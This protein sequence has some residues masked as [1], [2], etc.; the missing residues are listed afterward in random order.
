MFRKLLP[1]RR[2]T[3]N[4]RR[5]GMRLTHLEDR[6]VP[7][8]FVVNSILDNGVG[9]TL[10]V[11]IVAANA[12]PGADTIT[13]DAGVFGSAETIKLAS[14]EI[15]ISG[16]LIID[17]PVAALTISGENA[18]RIFNINGAGALAVSIQDVTLTKGA[19]TGAADGGAIFNQDENLTLTNCTVSSSNSASDG[20]AIRLEAAGAKLT[21]DSCVVS[22]NTATG[23]GGAISAANN[24]TVT[25]FNTAFSSNKSAGGGALNMFAGGSLTIQGCTLSSN[26]STGVG[27]AITVNGLFTTATFSN[28]TFHA[29]QAN[30]TGGAIVFGATFTTT[31]TVQNCT[32]SAN[33]AVAGN[34]GAIARTAGSGTLDLISTIVFSNSAGTTADD[35]FTTGTANATLCM[36]TNTTGVTSFSGDT[37]TNTNIGVDPLL[38]T[39]ASN[40]GPTQTRALLASS[41]AIDAGSNPGGLT[42]DQRGTGYFRIRGTA[43]DIGA[44]ETPDDFVVTNINGTGAG[45]LRQA[46]ADANTA[47]GAD[48][49]TFDPTVFA[50]ATTIP[51]A[52]QLSVTDSLTI[53]GPTAGVTVSGNSGSRIFS[54]DDGTFSAIVASLSNM[55]LTAGKAAQGAAAMIGIAD[56]LTLTNCVVTGNQTT[57]GSGGAFASYASYSKLT[58]IGCTISGN[59]TAG[60]GGAIFLANNTTL[61]IRDCTISGNSAGGQGG[62][63]YIAGPTTVINSTISGNSAGTGG[64]GIFQF[65]AFSPMTIRNSTVVGNTTTSGLGGGISRPVSNSTP[66]TIDSS[67]V[68]GN[69]APTG[70]D[71]SGKVANVATSLIGNA[72]GVTTFTGDAFTNSNIG[73]NPQLGALA[74]NGGPTLTHLPAITSPAVDAGSN[75]AVLTTDQRGSGFNRTF[76][77]GIDVGAIESRALIVRNT[78]DSGIGSLRQ[79]ILDANGLA[80]ADTVTFDANVFATAQTITLTGGHVAINESLTIT[81]PPVGVTIS[82]NKTGRIFDTSAA[83]TLAP[84]TLTDLTL[85]NGL[86]FHGGAILVD[87]ESLTFDHGVITG[88]DGLGGFGGGIGVLAGGTI[89]IS[90]S[91]ISNNGTFG[92]ALGGGIGFFKGGSFQILDSTLVGNTGGGGGVYFLGTATSGGLLARNSTF[93]D[94]HS[95][96][97]GGGIALQA[98]V[99][100][101]TVQNCTLTK[102]TANSDGGGIG[103]FDGS[104]S[105]LVVI[106]STIVHGNKATNTNNEDL[107]SSGTITVNSSLIGTKTGVTFF[108]GDTFTNANIGASPLLGPLQN[109]GGPTLTHMPDI[110]SKAINNGSNPAGLTTDQRGA[111]FFRVSAGAVDI[112]AVELNQFIVTNTNDSGAGSLRQAIVVANALAGV[113]TITFDPTVFATSKTIT[114]TSG[115]LVITDSVTVTGPTAMPTIS[116]NG[117]SRVF[118]LAT[119]TG[120]TAA[121]SNLAIA[122]G[123]FAGGTGGAGMAIA[124]S[125]VTLTNCSFVDNVVTSA[126]SGGAIR[127]VD[128]S[129][130]SLT[131]IGCAFANNSAQTNGGALVV[132]LAPGTLLV[133]DSSFT[134]N[135]V[136]G[137]GGAIHVVNPGTATIRNTTISSNTAGSDGGGIYVSFNATLNIQNSTITNNVATSGKGGGIGRNTTDV[138]TIESSIV[139]GNTNATA[140]D[141]S[142]P[143]SVTV[144]TSLIGSTVGVTGTFTGDTFTNANIGVNPLLGPLANNGGLTQTH[145]LLAG[146]PA[147]GNGSNPA[148][149]TTDQR[150]AG[151]ARPL[152][153]GVDIG[154][155]ESKLGP[156]VASVVVNGGAAQRSRVTSVTV[157]F[158]SVV[159][160]SGSPVSAFSLKRQSDNALPLLSAAVTNGAVTSVTLTFLAGPAVES[161]SLADGRYTLSVDGSQVSVAGVFGENFVMVGDPTQGPKLFRFFGDITGD[162]AV[163]AN[164]FIQFRLALGGSNPDFDF[165]NDGAVAASDFIQFRLR[166]G[167]SI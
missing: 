46:I 37:F 126:G 29:N 96:G 156:T 124:A 45:S 123:F 157:A 36:I 154:A 113:D 40:G 42:T 148:G 95:G 12:A 23:G 109:N 64:G 9:N 166:F 25:L 146:S 21:M 163:A 159:T 101:L 50:G 140:P 107:Y 105:G 147:F 22:A 30:T 110:N 150:G 108:V 5:H 78:N 58:L 1:R 162:G 161:A 8:G 53:A 44:V 28:C 149:L 122:K 127:M 114:L 86:A 59:T 160:F 138:T 94:N 115:E 10:R 3:Q 151:F 54:V 47:K 143:G 2:L 16:D 128:S 7:A 55:T 102:N 152:L 120:L 112:G 125:T 93:S 63:I 167:G 14:G 56:E 88:S 111:G 24:Q 85:T 48:T 69:S 71:L 34:G 18:S 73:V 137:D 19:T 118:N 97:Q 74:N 145:A 70:Q 117:S 13:F 39:L 80:G 31:L 121:F 17:G 77:S 131:I 130:G 67:I 82:G 116:G 92:G 51:L 83:P 134:S 165:D 60:H 142:L 129:A 133:Q 43:T 72:S 106:E 57:G 66:I 75:P 76:G 38:G 104:P 41:V 15:A 68:F 33:A 90:R 84:I 20:G 65:F 139:Y 98:F 136:V 27:G 119:V 144:N 52:S 11:Q 49:I 32:L 91:T 99:G 100:T 81:A 6:Y 158:D 4:I 62:G 79:N 141:L 135:S 61:S 35:L 132:I 89:V 164:D 153:G 103:R 26:S 155:F 87:D